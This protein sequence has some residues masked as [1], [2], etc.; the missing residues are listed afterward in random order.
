M[1]SIN[2]LAVLEK[3]DVHFTEKLGEP[4]FAA[5]VEIL[6]LNVGKRCNLSCRHCHVEAGNNRKEIMSG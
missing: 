4:L 6:Q 2:Q 1:K 5:G 3:H